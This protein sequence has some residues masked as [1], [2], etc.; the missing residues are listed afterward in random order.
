MNQE[1]STATAGMGFIGERRLAS[2][3]RQSTALVLHLPDQPMG[4]E[5]S[6]NPQGFR[7]ILVI[8]MTNGIHQSFMQPKLNP[9]AG[10]RTPDRF[11]EQLQQRRQLQR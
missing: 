2:I 7:R 9:L 8:A 11:S 3:A 10:E 6:P 4:R 1:Q 5:D